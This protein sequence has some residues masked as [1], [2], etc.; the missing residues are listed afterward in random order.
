MKIAQLRRIDF[1]LLLIFQTVMTHRQL[2]AAA[3]ELQLTQ[4]ALSHALKRL[5]SIVGEDLF[6]RRQLGME[7]TECARR[8]IGP[9]DDILR[10]AKQAL[11]PDTPFDPSVS[12]RR[13]RIAVTDLA[14]Q[15][16][17][18]LLLAGHGGDKTV[19]IDMIA[20]D[21]DEALAL[22]ENMEADLALTDA[23]KTPPRT[24]SS[25]V[26][27][28][29]YSVASRKGGP[30]RKK[31][32][33]KK[34]CG[35][36]HIAVADDPVDDELAAGGLTR[37]VAA[38]VPDFATALRAASVSDLVVTIPTAVAVTHAKPLGLKLYPPPFEIRP[39]GI[40]VLRHD[41]RANDDG[42]DW[43]MDSIVAAAAAIGTRK[44]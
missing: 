6:V 37:K 13:F 32:N 18:P 23:G 39:A 44:R 20:C 25:H 9:V 5:R 34:Y 33:I 8:L 12:E 17:A 10:T 38:T 40:S 22:L 19:A 27:Q 24:Q 41:R 11:A 7:P 14:G 35:A 26:A 30:L 3:A 36:R 16:F 4:S 28:T 43:L 1:G 21:R 42:L 2:T 29:G 15:V 31:L